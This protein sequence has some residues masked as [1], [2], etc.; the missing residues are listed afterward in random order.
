MK[1]NVNVNGKSKVGNRKAEKASQEVGVSRWEI[2]GFVN[3]NVKE[4]VS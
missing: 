2:G 4:N 1:V 3:V